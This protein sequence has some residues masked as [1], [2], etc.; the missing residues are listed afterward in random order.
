VR[1]RTRIAI[2]G[3]VVLFAV[4]V[5]GWFVPRTVRAAQIEE[6]DRQ[7]ASAMPPAA[8]LTANITRPPGFTT[9]PAIGQALSDVYVALLR[10]G[11]RDVAARSQMAEDRS[12]ELP[13]EVGDLLEGGDDVVFRAGIPLDQ[14]FAEQPCALLLI[15]ERCFQRL[16][17]DAFALP[18]HLSEAF[19]PGSGHEVHTLSVPL[20]PW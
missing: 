3:G 16:K 6:V 5:A 8:A 17:G 19:F 9:P 12:P 7:L 1:L 11:T 20:T 2:A 4:A 13:P 10:D 18:Q 15:V 14:Q